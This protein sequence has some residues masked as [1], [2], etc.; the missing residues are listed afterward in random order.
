MSENLGHRLE[1]LVDG[2]EP[3]D[4]VLQVN[5]REDEPPLRIPLTGVTA[6]EAELRRRSLLTEIEH[7][8]EIEAPVMYSESTDADPRAGVAI[9]PFRVTGV[10]LVAPFPDQV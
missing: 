6:D 4:Y 7:A 3:R 10:D 8:I 9:D 5:F 2:E 1:R